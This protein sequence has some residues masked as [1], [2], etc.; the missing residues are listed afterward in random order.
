VNLIGDRP[1]IDRSII[2]GTS[3]T[4]GKRDEGER[5]IRP[6]FFRQES[7][8]TEGLHKSIFN[9]DGRDQ[10]IRRERLF[11][12]ERLGQTWTPSHVTTQRYRWRCSD[13]GRFRIRERIKGIARS[14]PR[15]PYVS[16]VG[17]Q[18]LRNADAILED[19]ADNIAHRV[20]WLDVGTRGTGLRSLPRSAARQR[21]YRPS[22]E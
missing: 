17:D 18:V 16:N 13:G 7:P 11:S 5:G 14:E 2:C 10:P 19:L 6:L 21:P 8:R 15:F 3:A 12:G 22:D 9:D 1:N 4:L 20:R